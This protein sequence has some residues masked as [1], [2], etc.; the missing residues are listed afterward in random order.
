[1]SPTGT[2]DSVVVGIDGTAAADDALDWA[3][4]EAAA[5]GCGLRIV[6]AFRPSLIVDPYGVVPPL[7]DLPV[8]WAAAE[9]VLV[10]AAARARSVAADL[11]VT[12]RL[13]QGTAVPALLG[14]AC[15]AGVL[16]LGGRSGRGLRGRLSRSVSGQVAAQAPCPVVIVRPRDAVD[17]RPSPPRVV[18]GVDESASCTAAVGFAFHAAC[19][20]GVPVVAVHAWIPD[21]PG[22]LEAIT[23]PPALAEAVAGRVLDRAVD[24]WRSAF[25]DVSVR[26]VL[27]RGEPAHA[28]LAESHGAAL[29]VIGTRGR[30]RKA[31]LGSVSDTVLRHN[32]CP[33]AIIRQDTAPAPHSAATPESEHRLGHHKSPRHR[34]WLA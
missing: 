10:Q 13:L 34:R 26:P 11:P 29:L 19:Q 22:D 24:R 32:K 5:R 18:V 16:V 25:A 17:A 15:D 20:R 9:R 1:M 30:A 7:G 3:S 27:V 2:R 8:V 23:G 28:L 14:E 4:A 6:H 12:A 33:L 31:V 21:P